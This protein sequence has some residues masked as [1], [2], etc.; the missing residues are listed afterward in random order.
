MKEDLYENN[1]LRET[2]GDFRKAWA[3]VL[4]HFF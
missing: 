2:E 4:N 1:L 3:F